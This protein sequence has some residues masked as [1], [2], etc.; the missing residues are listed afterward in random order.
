MQNV[1]ALS[2]RVSSSKNY[3]ACYSITLYEFFFVEVSKCA[4]SEMA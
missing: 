2:S 1:P 3:R 4:S